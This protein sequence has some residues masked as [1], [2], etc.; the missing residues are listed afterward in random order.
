M[1]ALL[2]LALLAVWLLVDPNDYKDRISAAVKESTGRELSMPGELQL[3]VYPW[4]GLK[5]GP[6]SIGNPSG[7][8]DEPFA[9]LRHV[10]MRVKLLPLLR[11]E[12][13]VGRI[14]ID[15]LDLSL[16]QNGAGKGNWQDW[17]GRADVT[18]AES[19][20]GGEAPSLELAGIV[21]TNGRVA[22]EDIVARNLDIEAGRVAP[23]ARIPVRMK[24]DLLRAVDAAPLPLAAAFDLRLDL[25][26][27]RYGLAQ[28]SVEGTVPAD[29]S[30]TALPWTFRSPAVELDLSA[31]TLAA[32][33]FEASVSTARLSGTVAGS[34]L[35]DAPTFAGDF[36]LQEIAP[37]DLMKL[38]DI[39]PPV[40]RDPAA[41]S[42]LQ[43]QGR[44]SWANNV[45][46]ADAIKMQLDDAGFTGRITYNTATNAAEFALSL[47]HIDLDRYQPPPTD[48]K[49]TASDP[50]EL[51][52]DT[53]KPL[54]AQGSFAIGAIKTAGMQLTKLSAAVDIKGG[55]ARF[56]PLQAQLYGGQYSGNISLDMRQGPPRLS[57]TGSL[58]GIDI[59]AL[60][61]D[62]ADSERLSGRGTLTTKLTAA[63]RNGDQLLETLR[64]SITID[65][66]DGAVR[67]IDLWYEIAQAESL[68][69]KRTLAGGTN[70][71]RTAF[72]AFRASAEVLDGVATTKDLLIAS[73]LLRV[74]G[75]GSSNLLTQAVDY[76]ITATILKAPPES[77]ENIAQL[78]RVSVPV[79]VTG[80]FE[81]P[82]IRADLAGMAKARV[83]QEI[84]QKKDAVKEKL[85]DEVQKQLKN[86]FNR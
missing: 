30:A 26:K 69:Q 45:V 18:R 75:K 16:K 40:T 53:L 43:A 7:F 74:T 1:V 54:R 24:L 65:L 66:A 28:L 56:A 37:R 38:L 13:Q 34:K 64:G 6:A 67:G 22:F 46:R 85:K 72:D 17:G 19:S 36:S 2:A 35:V 50:I 15:G 81:D 61:K 41:L 44:Y 47:D 55:V 68:L 63:G 49:S 42:R 62:F 76:D 33:T 20:G 21:V 73:Q 23:G 3:S 25:D 4:L 29:G 10:E 51:P 8:D 31:Q 70:T 77:N 59:A 27:Q 5:F 52:I 83:K 79:R 58:G 80:T 57:M 9:T 48:G 11:K 82:K 12:L 86:L 39:V 14:E 78:V 60:M 71:K 84:E 32:A